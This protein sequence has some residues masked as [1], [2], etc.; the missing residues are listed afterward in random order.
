MNI[1][2]IGRLRPP[3]P[4]EGK[5]EVEVDRERKMVIAGPQGMHFNFQSLYPQSTSTYDIFR[6]SVEILLDLY[7][8]GFN[9]C[10]LIGGESGSGKTY[11]MA[12]I[13][14]NNTGMVP[15][16]FDYLFAK[17]TGE[18]YMPETKVSRHDYKVNLQMLEVYNEQIKD[19]LKPP[20]SGSNYLKLAHSPR[21]GVHAKDATSL[22]IKDASSGSSYFQ[23]GLGRRTETMT[24]FGPAEKHATTLTY[25]DLEVKVG[26]NPKPN[27]SRFSIIELPGVEKLA[28]NVERI[29]LREGPALSQSLIALNS[30]IT[31]LASNPQPERI[32]NY[33]QSVLTQLL[34]EELG[35]NCKT[36]AII[37]IKP[38]TAFDVSNTLLRFCL[39]LSQV[40]NFPVVNDSLAQ[41]LM[42][43]Y[44]TKVVDMEQTRSS[45]ILMTTMPTSSMPLGSATIPNVTTI[46]ASVPGGTNYRVVPLGNQGDDEIRALQTENLILKDQNERL[47][48]RLESLTGKFGNLSNTKTDL[49]QQ[50]LASEEEKLKVSQSL[51]EM[52]I[53]NNKIK[54]DAEAM[55]FEL[56]NKII[57]LENQLM[58]A[59]NERDRHLKGAKGAKERLADMEKDRK[60]MADEYVALKANYSAL[61]KEHHREVS[62]NEELAIEL[63]NLVNAKAALMRQVRVLTNGDTTVGDPNAEIARIKALVAK[64]SNGRVRV[65]DI[66]GNQSDRDAAADN[67][68]SRNRFYENEI[69]RLKKERGGD[70]ERL[71][72]RLTNL[73]KELT[74][75][76][77]LARE[78]QQQVSELNAKVII[79]RGENEQLQTQLNRMQ[80]KAKDLGEDYR[81][82]LVKYIEDISE[83]VD[84][85]SGVPNA[86]T[87]AR[88]RE[89]TNSM[90]KDIRRSHRERENQLSHAAQKFKDRVKHL[91]HKYEEVLVGYRNLRQLCESRGVSEAEMGPDEHHMSLGDAEIQSAHLKE[92]AR[93]KAEM[94][95]VRSDYESTKIRSGGYSGDKDD[96]GGDTWGQLRKQM[97]EFTLNTQQGLEQERARLLSENGVLR[98]QLRESQD[99]IDNHLVRY[100][101]EIL[102]LRRMCGIQEDSIL[103]TDTHNSARIIRH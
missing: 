57:T 67:L 27:R 86:A 3:S 58:E 74:Q 69:S 43:N 75:A 89:Y 54:E 78:R 61:T 34:Q 17:L 76:R 81:A 50:L 21:K 2:V 6:K 16:I 80:H 72:G 31:S 85:G 46:P 39:N 64:N 26:E 45:P 19:L 15:M 37:C 65:D 32:I 101:E 40:T 99:Y 91:L 12:G 5:V 94:S 66:I 48:H 44:R 103:L 18:Q 77:N 1:E 24:D 53:E 41:N 25:I 100:K 84:K 82:R 7:M 8:A 71:E 13:S 35:G 56:T 83:Y 52:Q 51:V 97:R 10:L 68:L 87:E 70:T 4:G 42:T 92:I 23:Q 36:Q 20:R 29:R 38:R 95:N 55:K 9:I 59:E 14:R 88:L 33:K 62:R 98:E 79:L 60:D 96:G 49:S 93:L 73:Y 47:Q 28:D 102:R 30:V 22:R 90:L 11:T 63:L